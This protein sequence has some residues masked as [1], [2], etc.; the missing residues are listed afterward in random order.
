VA[1]GYANADDGTLHAIKWTLNGGTVDLSTLGTPLQDPQAS[2]PLLAGS[3]TFGISADGTVIV[4]GSTSPTVMNGYTAF[5]RTSGDNTMRDL[6]SL[7]G[8]GGK[9]TAYGVDG[10]GDVVVGSSEVGAPNTVHAFRWVLTPNTTTGV[11]SDLDPTSVFHRSLAT[12]VN[13]DGS[14]VIGDAD[15]KA[16]RWDATNGMTQL[17]VLSGD[18]VSIANAVSDDGA[19]IVGTSLPNGNPETS[20]GAGEVDSH[21]F[22]WTAA[23]GMKDLTTLLA[24]AGVDMTGISLVGATSVTGDGQ[25]IVGN[26]VFPDTDTNSM[27]AFLARYCDATVAVACAATYAGQGSGAIGGITGQQS[28]D[29]SLAQLA[30]Q[31]NSVPAQLGGT[32]DLLLGELQPIEEDGYGQIFG[33]VGSFTLGGHG[34]Y[35]AGNGL[36]VLGG[37]ALVDQSVAG[38]SAGGPLFGVAVRYVAPVQL[39]TLALK[40]FAEGGLWT[41]PSLS[42][43]FSRSYANGSGV[44]TGESDASGSA[45]SFYGRAGVLVTPTLD[46]ELAFSVTL[47]RNWLNVGAHSETLSAGNPFPASFEASSSGSTEI[48][49]TAQWTRHLDSTLNLTL[50]ASAGRSVGGTN[51]VTG[52]V[53]GFGVLTGT[54][55]DYTFGEVGAKL[56]WKFSEAASAQG[57]VLSRFSNGIGVHTQFGAGLSMAF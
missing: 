29:N 40:P 47:A 23:T 27:D 37:A 54:T 44:A 21:A 56:D 31:Q 25:F 30:D 20:S 9:S 10:D 49:G 53:S 24:D 46:D 51:A 2:Q 36:S 45:F 19:V 39:D 28:V 33:S 57:F 41:A 13:F 12:A 52:D 32:A 15:F 43:H 1:A 4:G 6:G 42:M 16:M 8:V 5:R 17:G 55:G 14:V 38:A 7:L 18:T 11:M 3:Q 34:R 26:G 22:R 48:K 50:S 35:N